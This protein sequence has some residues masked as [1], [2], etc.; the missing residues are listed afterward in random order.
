[1]K[2]GLITALQEADK[3]GEHKPIKTL[4]IC[5]GPRGTAP[6]E[7]YVYPTETQV[8][9]IVFSPD[10]PT[11]EYDNPNPS[12]E[13]DIWI[14]KRIHDIPTENGKLDGRRDGDRELQDL[15]NNIKVI[16]RRPKTVPGK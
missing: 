1:L 13:D 3:D 9:L 7:V 2:W 16:K 14:V 4:W 12:Q 10:L 8:T 11:R 6:F 15:G 5:S